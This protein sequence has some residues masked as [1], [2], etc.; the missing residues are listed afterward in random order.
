M[1]D[2]LG[3]VGA[4]PRLQKLALHQGVTAVVTA[5]PFAQLEDVEGGLQLHRS[6]P[7]K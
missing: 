1:T 3:A 6:P 7:P 4:D 5:Y 2:A